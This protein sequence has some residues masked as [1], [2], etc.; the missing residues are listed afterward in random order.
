MTKP[1]HI[2]QKQSGIKKELNY[3]KNRMIDL[4]NGLCFLLEQLKEKET[5]FIGTEVSIE[6]IRIRSNQVGFKDIIKTAE[7]LAFL[8]NEE[9]KSKLLKYGGIG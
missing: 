3:L 8:K 1:N 9:H 4:N 2:K 5:S 7:R 6:D